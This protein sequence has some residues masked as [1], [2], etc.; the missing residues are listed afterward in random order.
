MKQFI[1]LLAISL[2][3]FSGCSG[4]FERYTLSDESEKATTSYKNVRLLNDTN[5]TKIIIST[6]YLN[7]IYPNYTDGLAHF[8]VAFYSPEHNNTLYFNKTKRPSKSEYLLLL[9]K[10]DALASEKLDRDDLLVELMPISN[11][12]SQ[13]YYVRYELPSEKPALVLESDH[14]EQAVITYQKAKE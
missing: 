9:N 1:I 10:K 12:W 3:I 8:L 7:D 4:H 13:Y 5:K 2:T 14:T 11:N 6:V